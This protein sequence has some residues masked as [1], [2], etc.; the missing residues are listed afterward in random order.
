MD[1]FGRNFAFP[2][3]ISQAEQV[4]AAVFQPVLCAL[5]CCGTKREQ[6]VCLSAHHTGFGDSPHSVWLLLWPSSPSSWE[7]LWALLPVLTRPWG[8][9]PLPFSRALSQVWEVP[10]AL[11]LA[12]NF[13]YLKTCR[14]LILICSWKTFWRQ[15]LAFFFSLKTSR[16]NVHQWRSLQCHNWLQLLSLVDNLAG[17]AIMQCQFSKLQ[18]TLG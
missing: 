16:Q 8:W 2:D 15:Q 13:L 11:G 9:R 3:P 14:L 1:H 18:G 7:V 10:A 12:G 5:E 17:S 4:G 6:C